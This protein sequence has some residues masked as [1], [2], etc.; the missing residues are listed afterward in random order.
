MS[1]KSR[2]LSFDRSVNGQPFPYAC[3]E[4]PIN[5]KLLASFWDWISHDSPGIDQVQDTSTHPSRTAAACVKEA[6][7]T[8]NEGVLNGLARRPWPYVRAAVSVNPEVP[9]SALWGDGIVWHGLAAD[10]DPWVRGMTLLHSPEPP[11]GLVQAME[12]R[13]KTK[14]RALAGSYRN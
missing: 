4:S 3:C 11:A 1:R 13:I 10:P 9:D 5:H 8:D 2:K 12:D 14:T 7:E 6:S